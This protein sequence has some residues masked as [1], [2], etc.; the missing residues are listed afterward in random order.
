MKLQYIYR[1]RKLDIIY[2][3]GLYIHVYRTGHYTCS[4]NI[5]SGLEDGHIM[6]ERVHQSIGHNRHVK[7]EASQ[8]FQVI[9]GRLS[10]MIPRM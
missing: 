2:D 6:C 3:G 7:A 4:C 8:L 5:N 1:P 9:L 10:L